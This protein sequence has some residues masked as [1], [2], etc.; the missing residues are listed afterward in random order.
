MTT[1]KCDLKVM[2]KNV[3]NPYGDYKT[4]IRCKKEKKSA[5]DNLINHT[6]LMITHPLSSKNHQM[7]LQN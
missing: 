4:T 6:H 3:Y 7:L 5:R 1:Y 2:V